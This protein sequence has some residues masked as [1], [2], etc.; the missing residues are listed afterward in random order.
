MFRERPELSLLFEVPFCSREL[1]T[2][3][4]EME[5]G[6]II[7]LG[8]AEIRAI[9]TP[10]HSPGVISYIIKVNDGNSA[11][12]AG[13]QGGAGLNTLNMEYYEYFKIDAG[14]IARMRAA[15]PEG[16]KKLEKEKVDITLGNHPS[17]NRTLE[18]RKM[19]LQNPDGPNLFIDPSEWQ[20][21][22]NDILG[23]YN[24]MLAEEAELGFK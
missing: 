9:L 22:L 16:I 18:K 8:N 3:D 12:T 10:G 2:P 6:D 19:M 15:F 13:M 21:Y 17:H 7:T 1:F 5:D 14:E 20:M 4:A 11:Y 23:K 24:I